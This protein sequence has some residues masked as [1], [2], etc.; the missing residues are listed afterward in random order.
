MENMQTSSKAIIADLQEVS[1]KTSKLTRDFYRANGKYSERQWSKYWATFA[2]FLDAA[3]IRVTAKSQAVEV[4]EKNEQYGDIWEVTLPKTNIHTLEQLLAYCKVDL[5]VWEVERFICNKWEMGFKDKHDLADSLP[6]FQVKAFLRKK[7]AIVDAR[8]ELEALKEQFGAPEPQLVYREQQ[9]TGNMLEINI[10][11]VHVGKLAWPMETGQPPY[12]VQIAVALHDRAL[13]TLIERTSHYAYDEILY[14]V[15]NDLLNSTDVENKTTA[16]TIVTTDGRFQKTFYKTREMVVRAIE[17]LRLIAPVRVMLV[18]GN[19]DTLAVW[20]LGDSLQCYF[21]NY[22]DVKIDN[23][24]KYRKYHQFGQVMLGFTHGDKGKKSDYPLLM[25]TEKPEMFGQ[26]KFREMHTGHIHQTKLEEQHGVR[27]RILP[28]LCPADD[29]HS[30][31][32]Y[33]GNQRNAEAYIWNRIEGLLGTACYS[34]ENQ[35]AIMTKRE[36]V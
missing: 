27:V 11:D 22:D 10:P 6:L 33:I 32:G 23:E 18:P 4:T 3:K 14:V 1:K 5:A 9:V 12:D 25:A 29:W 19:H 21:R 2:D 7:V 31:N 13:D 20:H 15:G 8:Q 36:L 26:T 17:K 30:E 34:D 28:A 16:G 35:P 24:P